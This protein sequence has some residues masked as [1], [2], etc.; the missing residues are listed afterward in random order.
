[1]TC[2]ARFVAAAIAATLLALATPA[3]A[4]DPTGTV[5]GTIT[6]ASSAALQGARVTAR[7]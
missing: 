6:D 3:A 4:Q 5:E 1:M 7:T 2:A